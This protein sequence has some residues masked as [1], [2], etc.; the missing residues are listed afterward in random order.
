VDYQPVEFNYI[1]ANGL[2]FKIS[3][4]GHGYGHWLCQACSQYGNTDHESD[5]ET[6]QREA[7]GHAE[8]HALRCPA[9]HKQ[10]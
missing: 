1:A 7:R 3:D 9:D 10:P 4:D 2:R 6:A 8:D 5:S